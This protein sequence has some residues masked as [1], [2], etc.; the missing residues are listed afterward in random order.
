VRLAAVAICCSLFVLSLVGFNQ[1]S[2]DRV[3]GTLPEPESVPYTRF[4]PRNSENGGPTGTALIVH[5]LNSNKEFMYLLAMCLADAGFQTWVIDLP[6]HG[7]S[8]G[9]FNSEASQRAIESALESLPAETVV[10]GHSLG[11]ALLADLALLRR[12]ETA[13]LLSPPPIPLGPI[14]VGRLLVVSGR[15]DA[16]RINAFIPALLEAGPT[17]AEWWRFPW[18]GHSTALFN[19]VQHG[20][21]VEW[22]G[23]PGDSLRTSGRLGWL[24]LMVVATLVVPA[25]GVRLTQRAHRQPPRGRVAGDDTAASGVVTWITTLAIALTLLEFFNPVSWLRI[26]RTDYLVGL[27]LIAGLILW[28]GQ[29]VDISPRGALTGTLAAGY[30]IAVMAVA[31]TSVMH[32]IPSGEQWLRFPILAAAG[33]PLCLHDEL[34][35]RPHAP[36][37]RAWGMFLLTRLLIWSAVMTG[38]LL[39]NTDAAFLVLITH[40]VVLAWLPLWWLAGLVARGTGEPGAAALF[41]AL[42]Q[43]WVFAA[44]FVT[45]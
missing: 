13:V 24:T 8:S 33:L 30:I 36:W 11:A 21:I 3:D 6:G 39:L 43:G 41:S 29:K 23:G 14:N 32:L 34:A 45:I 18:A 1:S 22:I 7:D 27:L 40:L 17:D 15:F 2:P 37:W 19:P 26:F 9:R 4:S 44:L 25:A 38:V 10:I 16:P 28:R 35:L 20:M 5:G 31:G 12:F 42:V